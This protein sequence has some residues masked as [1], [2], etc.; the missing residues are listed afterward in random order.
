MYLDNSTELGAGGA[1]TLWPR[2]PLVPAAVNFWAS[3]Q[4]ARRPCSSEL[5]L[6]ALEVSS[7]LDSSVISGSG[8]ALLLRVAAGGAAVRVRPGAPGLLPGSFQAPPFAMCP[9]WE[10][11]EGRGVQPGPSPAPLPSLCPAAAAAS[12]RAGTT[13]PP[14][15]RRD[16]GSI[17]L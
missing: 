7:S 16:L 6:D 8:A 17:R 13:P 2:L 5:G 12:P 4:V 15:P 9:C 14:A 11:G 10:A 3:K 1:G